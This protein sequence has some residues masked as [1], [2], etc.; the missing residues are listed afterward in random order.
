MSLDQMSSLV[1]E[2]VPGTSGAYTNLASVGL[3]LNTDGTLTL[4]ST[5]LASA[6]AADPTSVSRLFVTDA[7]TG[8]TGVMGTISS[9]ID[10]MITGANAPIQ[11]EQDAFASRIRNISNE[12]AT[13]QQQ[14][15][16]YAT[17]LQ[18]EFAK[19]NTTLALYKQ[20]AGAINQG[21]SSNNSGT[22]SVL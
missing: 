4:D 21:N 5:K 14:S 11:A 15:D 7:T 2:Q 13:M 19:M 1:G 18:Q 9:T 6:L 22:N 12:I 16:Q 20:M 3:N 10:A 17:Q 8:A